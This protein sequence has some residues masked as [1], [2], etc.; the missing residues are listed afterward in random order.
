VSKGYLHRDVAARNILIT[1]VVGS[2]KVAKVADFGLCRHMDK[3]V[4][5]TRGGRLPIKWMSV[6]AL[7]TGDFSVKSDVFVDFSV[8][9]IG[10]GVLADGHLV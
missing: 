9:S 8:F 1:Q 7:A 10:R 3:D 5:T 2:R 6:E 4:Y